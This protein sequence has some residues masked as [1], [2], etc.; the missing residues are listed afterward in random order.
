[1][2]ADSPSPSPDA[3]M[4]DNPAADVTLE[5]IVQSIPQMSRQTEVILDFFVENE[6]VAYC[7]L[8]DLETRLDV[9]AVGYL[10]TFYCN[11]LFVLWLAD[12][13]A[14]LAN[15]MQKLHDSK[16]LA[17]KPAKRV[18]RRVD[19]MIKLEYQ[20]VYDDEETDP[21]WSEL[22]IRA[23]AKF[24]RYIYTNVALHF[25]RIRSQVLKT[26]LG[27]SVSMPIDQLIA[28]LND[29]S[30]ILLVSTRGRWINEAD[31][32]V[33]PPIETPNELSHANIDQLVKLATFLEQDI[34]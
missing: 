13:R 15:L 1:M 10:E 22:D 23:L 2:N 18:I 8:K 20:A 7:S 29:E 32:V 6:C 25:T 26:M 21:R 14:E 11:Y 34:I 3:T 28:Y 4:V 30:R 5:T 31:L 33:P 12:E 24:K 17:S 9:R 16:L 19:A 27:L